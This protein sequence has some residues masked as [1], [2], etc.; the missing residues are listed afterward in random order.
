MDKG[1]LAD[2]EMVPEACYKKVKVTAQQGADVPLNLGMPGTDHLAL[3][4]GQGLGTLHSAFL[5]VD[6]VQMGKQHKPA[7]LRDFKNNAPGTV[8]EPNKGVCL[9]G[10]RLVP[11]HYPGHH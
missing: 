2:E 7:L 5:V 6:L 10:A 8:T 3:Q 1:K 4:R 9:T 11:A